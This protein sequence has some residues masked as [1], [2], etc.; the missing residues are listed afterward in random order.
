MTWIKN[1]VESI[2]S[3]LHITPVSERVFALSDE[4]SDRLVNLSQSRFDQLPMNERDELL[5]LGAKD[6]SGKFGGVVKALA[7]E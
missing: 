6:F 2:W 1:L 5:S 7:R 4:E 3:S